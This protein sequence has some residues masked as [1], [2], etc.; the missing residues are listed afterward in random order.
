[1]N[2]RSRGF[3]LMEIVIALVLVSLIMLG[4]LTALRSM[5]GAAT[6]VDE[7]GARVDDARLVGNFLR[8]TLEQTLPLGRVTAEGVGIYFAGDSASMTW[9]APLR[10]GPLRGGVHVL[11]LSTE[12]GAEGRA[13][14][15]QAAPY[16]GDQSW[17]DW[18]QVEPQV[19]VRHV[20]SF[21]LG[22]QAAEGE[23]WRDGWG[24][25]MRYPARVSVRLAVNGRRWPDTV[26]ALVGAR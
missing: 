25:A 16:V 8:S 24:D 15:L 4:L 19:L 23:D 6:R 13:L 21:Q 7:V 2:R 1:M 10:I 14:I 20:D 11:R 12:N 22:Y 18:S 5:G 26:V 9:L 17:P 3:T